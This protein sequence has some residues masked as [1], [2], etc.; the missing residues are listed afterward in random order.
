MPVDYET[1]WSN[2][3]INPVYENLHKWMEILEKAK[4]EPERDEIV[5]IDGKI[6]V[7]IFL[8]AIYLLSPF[9]H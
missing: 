5:P 4:M 6:C 1:V 3:W 8:L 2:E 7:L 9:Y